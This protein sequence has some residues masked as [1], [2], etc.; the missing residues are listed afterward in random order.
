MEVRS[1]YKFQVTNDSVERAVT[2][3]R[4]IIEQEL[5]EDTKAAEVLDG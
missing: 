3:I 5:R 4:N 2:E 1:K